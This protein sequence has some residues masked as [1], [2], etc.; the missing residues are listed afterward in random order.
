LGDEGSGYAM[1]LQALKVALAHEYGW[2]A[3]TSLTSELCKLYAVSELKNIIQPLYKNQITPAQISRA[4]PL[5]LKQAAAQDSLALEI[6]NN[7]AAQLC[8]LVT[9]MATMGDLSNCE[10]HLWGGLFK[11]SAAD[12]FIKTIQSHPIIQQRNIVLINQ[13]QENAT[14]L[15]AQQKVCTSSELQDTLWEKAQRL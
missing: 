14:T 11:S 12:F 13:A 10:I 1:G 9:T 3:P 5:V 15:F 6:V 2:G 7:T 8:D 4:T